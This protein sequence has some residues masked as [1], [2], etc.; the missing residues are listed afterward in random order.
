MSRFMNFALAG[1]V[2]MAV[3]S[4]GCENNP[5]DRKDDHPHKST[6]GRTGAADTADKPA[7]EKTATAQVRP[8]PAPGMDE[9]KGT[10]DFMS[11]GDGIKVRYDISGLTPDGKH[12][13]HIHEKGDLSDPEFQSAG[14]HFNPTGSGHG[15]PEGAERHGGDLGN[16]KADAN[17]R[18][19]GE[20]TVEGVS[21]DDPKT[22]IVGR[23][24]IVHEKADDLAT[25]PSGNSGARVGGGIIEAGKN[26]E[27]KGASG[28]LG[29]EEGAT[30]DAE[31]AADAEA[32]ADTD[33]GADAELGAEVDTA[34]DA[35]AGA[36]AE[37]E[38]DADRAAEVDVDADADEDEGHS[39][40]ADANL[41]EPLGEKDANNPKLDE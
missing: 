40:D 41:D 22:G 32:A 38:A 27:A 11:T 6:R 4:G 17:G 1:V 28:R 21:I 30:P 24:I 12:G 33:A 9:V 31:T 25:D 10:V 20:I 3:V 18:A 19:K 29:A 14:G 34:A 13:F 26:G 37:L 5:F 7:A 35:D 15:G 2:S 16:I 39:S 23:S 36:D 8:S